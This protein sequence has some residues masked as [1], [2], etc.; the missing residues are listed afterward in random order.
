MKACTQCG[1]CCT[2]SNF[3]GSLSAT[4]ED[5]ERWRR[6]ERWDILAWCGIID[7]WAD[8]WVSPRTGDE[9]E[10]CP[11]VRKQ[12]GKDKYDCLIY[13]TRPEVCRE[14]PY[15]VEQ[16][17]FCGCEMLDK[18]DTDADVARF[19]GR[20]YEPQSANELHKPPSSE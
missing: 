13:E 14:F 12:R 4:A 7:D 16:M 10:R 15:H 5:L 8:L 11:F 6:E 1:K 20:D 3:M 17:K 2:N 9:A 19:M 18:G